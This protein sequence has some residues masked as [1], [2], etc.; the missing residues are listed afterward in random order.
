MTRPEA[1]AVRGLVYH[2]RSRLPTVEDLSLD[3]P[4]EGEVLVRMAAAGVCHSDLHVIDGEW[5]RPSELVLGHEGAGVIEALGPDVRVRPEGAPLEVGGV[6]IGDLVSLAWTA[7]CGVCAACRRGEGWLC[8]DP[9]GR[10]HRMDVSISRLRRADG[11]PLG[12]YLGVGTFCSAQVVAVEAAIPVDPRT[13]PAVAA[14]IGCAASTGIGAVR[15]TAGVRPG[16]SVV[17]IGL[18]GV[19]MAAL[20]AAVDIGAEPIVAVDMETSKQE[21]ATALGSTWAGGP[22]ELEG[23]VA[24][25]AS[26]GAD[27]VFECIGRIETA[28]LAMAATRPGGTTTLVGMTPMG[29]RLG[30]DVYDFVNEGKRLLGSNYGSSVPAR[31]FP[32][33]ASAAVEGR[34]PLERLIEKTID[35]DGIDAA[36][37]AMRRRVGGRRIVVYPA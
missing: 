33:I 28:A 19:G 34:L 36:F 12:T 7:P 2:G 26:G 4:R 17:V 21:Q 9:R 31:D 13:S 27:H 30:V 18:G 1:I 20:M 29:D 3:P 37:D 22:S 10:D 6:R 15:T 32:A 5:D 14:L 8:A 35:F 16:E 23:L 11:S 24:T 25:F